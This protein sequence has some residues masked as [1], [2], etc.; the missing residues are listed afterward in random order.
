MLVAL[1]LLCAA[2]G[3]PAQI[4]VPPTGAARCWRPSRRAWH[5]RRTPGVLPQEKVK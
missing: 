1:A 4:E 2:S 5:S 3:A